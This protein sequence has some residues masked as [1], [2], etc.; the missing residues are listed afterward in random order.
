MPRLN[1]KAQ[2][3]HIIETNNTSSDTTI[4]RAISSRSRA[5]NTEC[6]RTTE[7]RQEEGEEEEDVQGLQG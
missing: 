2:S 6:I 3:R 1:G 4:P 7:W 5:T